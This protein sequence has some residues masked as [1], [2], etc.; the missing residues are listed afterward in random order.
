[1]KLKLTIM[2]AGWMLLASAFNSCRQEEEKPLVDVP[3][4]IAERDSIRS[5]NDQQQQQ[6]DELNLFVTTIS[7]SLDSIA[8]QESLLFVS[9]D[10]ER[11]LTKKDIRERIEALEQLI[12]RQRQR[13]T[14]LEDSIRLRGMGDSLKLDKFQSIISFL[15]VQLGEKDKEIAKLR[16]DVSRKNKRITKL[17]SS[18]EELS[19]NIATLEQKTAVLDKALTTQDEMIN[20]CYLK[21]GT[22][23]ELEQAGIITKG[24]IFKKAKLN[25]TN[26]ANANFNEV[27][28]RNLKEITINS[29][30]PKILTPV[31]A[32]TYELAGNGYN[33]ILRILNPTKFWEVSNYLVIQI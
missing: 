1:M 26:F 9:S 10:P 19:S 28:I 20:K 5:I 7:S 30:N 8:T 4:L 2:L 29:K 17:Q 23:K 32:G 14:A 22:K 15:K 18:V 24:N 12:G 6:L 3:A 31:T 25:Y 11:T 21:I 33:T 27:D 13:I 16:E